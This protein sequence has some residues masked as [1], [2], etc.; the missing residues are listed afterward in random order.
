NLDAAHYGT[1]AEIG[2]GQEVARWFFRVGA[3]SGTI[4]TT[5]SAYDATVSDAIYGPTERYVSRQRL[6]KM[7]AHEY[8]LLCE[9]LEATRGAEAKF[10]AFADTV[11][12]RSFTR[13]EETHGWMG[14]RFQT[15]PKA[16]PSQIIVH[17]R[18]LDRE[19]LLQQ[20]ALGVIGVNFIH[21]ALYLHPDPAK[22]VAAFMDNLTTERIEVDMIKFDGPAFAGVDNRV[23][24]LQLVQQGLTEATMFTADGEVAQAA[25]V[26][27]KRPILVVRGSFRPI[28]N[29]TLDV[30]DCAR[31]QFARQHRN[32]AGTAVVL[33]E[34][35]L[36]HLAEQDVIDPRDFLDRADTLG[37]LG[38]T[39]L[40]SN[41]ARYF[42]LAAYLVRHT[43]QQ[44]AIAMGLRR[45]REMF[46]DKYYSDLDGG[47][48]EAFGR[49]FKN[50]LKLYIYPVSEGDPARLVTARELAVAPHLRHLYAHLLQN[51]HIADIAGHHRE[52]QDIRA[53]DVLS[54]IRTGDQKWEPMVPAPVVRMVKERKLFGWRG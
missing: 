27:H 32:Q 17:V 44:V 10:F 26:L 28:T 13:R 6:V 24:S 42:R 34:M 31:E 40:V 43:K 22:V 9:R 7:L 14:I 5:M 8:D 4:A 41:Y 15:A 30:I 2:A 45:L 29:A 46:D 21:A 25:D 49:M 3:A 23:M 38:L 53:R 47:I 19:N 54:R 35:T 51:G 12:A 16:P 33:T 20:E 36:R 1:F 37:S 50:D 52:Y 18:M 39:V 11:T 48:L